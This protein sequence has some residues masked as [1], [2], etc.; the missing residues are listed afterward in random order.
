MVGTFYVREQR[1][2]D[3]ILFRSFAGGRI[4]SDPQERAAT[5]PF[6]MPEASLKRKTGKQT[7]LLWTSRSLAAITPSSGCSRE[8]KLTVNA[9]ARRR[10]SIYLRRGNV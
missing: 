6:A 10:V 8:I 3:P 4:R 5:R 7:S 2:V 9:R 1:E